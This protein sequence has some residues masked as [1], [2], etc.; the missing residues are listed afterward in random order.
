MSKKKNLGDLIT[1]NKENAEELS[2]A[3]KK[4]A[5]NKDAIEKKISKLII[6]NKENAAEL[7]IVDAETAKRAEELIIANKE[8][9]FQNK[10]KEKREAELLIAN[11]EKSE[12]AAELII[13]N[14]LKEKREAELL[15]A[16][17]EKSERADELIIANVLKEKREAELLIA[18][19]E[20]SERAAELI[21]ANVLKAKREAELLIA[22]ID[23]AK[24]SSE[25]AIANKELDY[26]KIEESKRSAE[27]ITADI[28]KAKIAA[29]LVIANIEKAERAAETV[30]VS[31]ELILSKEKEK[32]S[33]K[34]YILNENLSYE[35]EKRKQLEKAL[36]ER[37]DEFQSLA[38]SMP[39][40]VWTTRADGWNTYFNQQ[41]VDYTGL[42][43][44]ESYGNGWIKP[45]H[46]ED[47][48][49]AWEAWQ[50]AVKNIAEYSIECRL[51][52]HDG[53]YHW[54]LIRGVPQISSGGEIIKWLGTCTD[55][56]KFKEVELALKESEKQLL[57]LNA[58]KDRFISILGH[59]L[60][61]PFTALIGLS[62]LLLENIRVY[63]TDETEVLLNHLKDASTDTFALLEDL[64]AWT[65][66]QSGKLPFNPQILDFSDI[67][68]NI[69]ESINTNAL[70]KNIT[71]KIS[72]I[73]NIS[74]FADN[75]MLKTVLR[76]LVSNA[77]KFTNNS[78]TININ[79]EEN[80]ENVTISVSDNG[81]GIM[82]DKLIKLFDI[83]HRQTTKGTEQES[84]TGL[85]LIL[86]KEFVE[87]H[88]GK[89]WVE[90]EV[91]KGSDFKFTLPI[92]TEAAT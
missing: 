4:A 63:S 50:N 61:S 46:P 55:I 60:R 88:G 87:K 78:G 66:S 22:H 86:C 79:A 51:R 71:I 43:L 44:E 10:E 21:I 19:E 62:D 18:N 1:E 74:I 29:E 40:M 90:S 2:V 37:E 53:R 57:R 33:K 82:P 8:L 20:K 77:I 64:L 5:L 92:F 70:S 14:V 89:I 30:F 12:R 42:T 38:E 91:G 48:Q 31:K 75:N 32:L 27:L 6:T 11:E 56:E 3:D 76:N 54:W 24:R 39:Q 73:K 80:S 17:E 23:K 13:A 65:S 67:C 34:L 9:A 72:T 28:E 26:Y 41:W 45:F 59:D 49:R 35:I 81:I 68:K 69:L 58:D 15:I 85:G 84:G 47:K 83:S 52:C 25:L 36:K 7:I 16:N